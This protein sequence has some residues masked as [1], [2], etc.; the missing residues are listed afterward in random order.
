MFIRSATRVARAVAVAY[1]L[2]LLTM[3]FLERYLVYPAPPLTRSDWTAGGERFEDVLFTSSDGTRLHGWYL[4]RPGAR[5]AVLYFHGNG[6][7]VADNADLIPLLADRLDAS[8]FLFDYRGYG[9]SGGKPTEAGVV[10]DGLA[11]QRWLA[12]RTGGP[13]EGVVLIGRSIGGGVAVACAAELGAEALV[14]Q[15]TFSRLTD[16]AAS[17]YPWLPVRLLM[18]NRYDSVERIQAYR[19]PLFASHGTADLVVPIELGRRLFATAPSQPKRFYEMPGRGHND[20]QPASYYP[21][22]AAFLDTAATPPA[23][24]TSKAA[25]GDKGDAATGGVPRPAT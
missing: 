1:L 12:A 2:I 8:V 14:L 10:A 7:Q 6:E 13:P 22:L 15:S 17:H 5:R 23:A 24:A 16:A 9:K 3:T 11:A 21:A 25:P 18:Q 4:D 19:G 20:P